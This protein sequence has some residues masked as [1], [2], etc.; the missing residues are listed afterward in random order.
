MG[1][2]S[3]P[4]HGRSSSRTPDGQRLLD[5]LPSPLNVGRYHSLTVEL[6]DSCAPRDEILKNFSAKYGFGAKGL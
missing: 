3:R 6:D 1:R 2:A 4:M 5:G